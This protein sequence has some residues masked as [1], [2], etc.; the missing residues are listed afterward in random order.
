M[1]Y[2][3]LVNQTIQ[4]INESNDYIWILSARL[5][6]GM[7]RL[8]FVDNVKNLEVK[9]DFSHY[10]DFETWSDIYIFLIGFQKGADSLKPF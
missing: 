10:I 4:E 8:Y 1:N 7:K 6:L 3:K 9:R 5:F 2:K